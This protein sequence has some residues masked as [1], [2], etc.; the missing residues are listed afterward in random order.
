M[1]TVTKSM[2][3][4]IAVS[5]I[6]GFLFT[7]PTYL[8]T[9]WLWHPLQLA[10]SIGIGGFVAKAL[11]VKGYQSINIPVNYQGVATRLGDKKTG[12][13]YEAGDHW[14][15]P[16]ISGAIPVD[17]RHRR[18]DLSQKL[19]ASAADATDVGVDGFVFV[20]VLNAAKT[21]NVKDLDESV[22]ELLESRIRLFTTMVSKAENAIRFRDLLAEYLELEPR[23]D[24]NTL[25]PAHQL[26]K[27]RLNN[28]PP[29]F[30]VDGGIDALMEKDTAGALK[31]LVAAWGA[32][33][34]EVEI[35]EFDIP[36]AV[37]A[38][39]L[40][41]ATQTVLMDAE[42]IR[43]TARKVMV[44]ELVAS[45]VNANTAMNSVD[46]LLGLG[47]KKDVKEITITD[48]E[49]VAVAFGAQ[50]AGVLQQLFARQQTPDST[51]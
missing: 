27:D 33:I 25:T 46:M 48:L 23:D 21:L 29:G 11:F 9:P 41:K 40:K 31:R 3:I 6:M 14:G 20:Q 36:E 50:I 37:K 12:T 30:V 15:F 39:N 32:K 28:L 24:E 43:N 51:T 10:L 2:W 35:E 7:V 49:K 5:I 18:I 38:A 8:A 4:G 17:M 45:G 1:R 42:K 47:I 19:T 22:R 16:G 13:I 34:E 26:V 44:D